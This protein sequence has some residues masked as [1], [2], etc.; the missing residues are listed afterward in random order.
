MTKEEIQKCCMIS[1]H[2]LNEYEEIIKQ[3]IGDGGVFKKSP[4]GYDV[5][6]LSLMIT[7][8]DAGF[9]EKETREYM[10]RALQ[11]E[12]KTEELLEMLDE[13][14]RHILEMI[15]IKEEQLDKLDYL[16]FQIKKKNKRGTI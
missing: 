15:H 12:D 16:R 1:D 14:L 8:H 10:K 3:V 9:S 11:R 5:G 6:M 13:K 2:I 7:L 4:E